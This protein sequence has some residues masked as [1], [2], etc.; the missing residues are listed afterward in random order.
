[1]KMKIIKIINVKSAKT[2]KKTKK[3]KKAKKK[4]TSVHKT[5][6]IFPHICQVFTL[7]YNSLTKKLKSCNEMLM[8]PLE[9]NE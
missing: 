5:D 9:S 3:I 7:R 2:K 4:T 6:C 1:M 8:L